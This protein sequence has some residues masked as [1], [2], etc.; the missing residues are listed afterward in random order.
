MKTFRSENKAARQHYQTTRYP[1]DLAADLGVD[2]KI[3]KQAPMWRG[4]L[5]VAAA[6]LL[7]VSGWWLSNRQQT[8]P[9][10]P[11]PSPMVVTPLPETPFWDSK[12]ASID[13]RG[14]GVRLSEV[15]TLRTSRLADRPERLTPPTRPRTLSL[16]TTPRRFPGVIVKRA[17]LSPVLSPDF[18]RTF[19]PPSSRSPADEH[20]RHDFT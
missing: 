11:M 13:P 1:G 6:I 2:A 8:V 10:G 5:A 20:P 16:G 4:A 9:L 14:V 3:T 19:R 18:P 15:P 12:A 7:A 17:V